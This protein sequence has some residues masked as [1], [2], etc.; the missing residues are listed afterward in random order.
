MNKL[1]AIIILVWP[2]K[3]QSTKL[4]YSQSIGKRVPLRQLRHVEV[5][6]E[7]I[8]VT[9]LLLSSYYESRVQIESLLTELHL[10]RHELNR[11][12]KAV[13][14]T[15]LDSLGIKVGLNY[16][17]YSLQDNMDYAPTY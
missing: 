5:V 7:L 6:K 4:Y 12:L 9:K 13:K 11:R 10:L 15:S 17:E 3:R 16:S 2:V 1:L 8:E 14:S